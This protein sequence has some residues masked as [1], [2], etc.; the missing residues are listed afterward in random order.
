MIWRWVLGFKQ[1]SR[2]ARDL[3]NQPRV[4]RQNFNYMLKDYLQRITVD[5]EN[6]LY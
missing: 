5:I 2:G 4:I 6:N 1:L 3:T